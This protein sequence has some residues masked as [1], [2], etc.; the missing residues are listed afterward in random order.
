MSP[1]S[2]QTAPPRISIIATARGA[3]KPCQADNCAALASHDLCE[4]ANKSRG[5]SQRAGSFGTT[6][7]R[8]VESPRL[9][10]A[11]LVTVGRKCLP[12][13][14]TRMSV[15]GRARRRDCDSSATVPR[16]TK[17]WSARTRFEFF[18]REMAAFRSVAN[19]AVQKTASGT[20]SIFC[21]C[22]LRSCKV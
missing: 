8:E 3:V 17:S 7:R 6:R 2:Y 5:H 13:E 14:D 22:D 20:S 11:Q 4:P 9:I 1:T 18:V 12:T 10:N 21:G 15:L 19:Y 16:P